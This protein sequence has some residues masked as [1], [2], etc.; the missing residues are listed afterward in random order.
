MFTEP[1]VIRSADHFE[2]GEE[3]HLECQVT[4]QAP[5]R[6]Q[7]E[8]DHLPVIRGFLDVVYLKNATVHTYE[9]VLGQ[10]PWVLAWVCI[11]TP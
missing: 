1:P 9:G 7:V 4:F 11:M 5:E 2:E 3:A 10:R 6:D 8:P